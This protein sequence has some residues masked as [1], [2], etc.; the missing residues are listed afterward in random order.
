MPEVHRLK[1]DLGGR[2]VTFDLNYHPTWDGRMIYEPEVV[3]VMGRFVKPGDCVID[4]GSNLGFFTL[5]ASRLVGDDG[6]V[7]AFDADPRAHK[8][9][10]KNLRLNSIGN[11]IPLQ[12]V[13]WSHDREKMRFWVTD[14]EG[15]SSVLELIGAKSYEVETR[16][17]DTLLT[18]PDAHP[19]FI[20]ID[21]EGAEEDILKG[22]KRILEKGVDCVV[23]EFNFYLMNCIGSS[24]DGIRKFMTDLGYDLFVI[25]ID[26]G[27]GGYLKPYLVGRDLEFKVQGDRQYM[28]VMFSTSEKVNE[29]WN[30]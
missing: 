9:L 25:S 24:P 11:V 4:A 14:R 15:Y 5:L 1:Y 18:D 29:L 16:C 30:A 17:L 2:Q 28:N 12:M 19:Q 22:A 20:K 21:C 23:L 7:F 8:D 26:D 6:L 27:K 10:C 3:N 13:L